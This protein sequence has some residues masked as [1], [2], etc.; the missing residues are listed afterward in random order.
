MRRTRP[1]VDRL[2]AEQRDAVEHP[3]GPLL[4]VAGPGTG[5]THVLVARICWLL[6][7]LPDISGENILA[8]TF[9]ERAAHEMKQRVEDLLGDRARGVWAGTFHS[10]C[11]QEILRPLCPGLEVLEDVDHWILL[12]R[13]LDQLG[14]EQFRRLAEPGRFLTDFCTFFSRCQDEL[15][16]PDEFE[17]YVARLAQQGADA[18]TLARWQEV[19]RAYRV[20]EQLLAQSLRVTFGGLL[21]EAIRVLDRHPEHL[22]RLRQRF[23]HILVDEFQDTNVAQIELLFRLAGE[24]RN[25][26]VVGDDDQAIYRF[27]GASF[28]SFRLFEQRCV[29]NSGPGPGTVLL[30]EN[31]RSTP[32]I[33]RVAAAVIACNADRYVPDKRL[34]TGRRGGPR[35]RLVELENAEQ[36]ACWVADEL[37]RLHAEGRPWAAC[38]VLYRQHRHRERLVLELARRKIPFVIRGLSIFTHTVV[39]DLLALLRLVAAPEDEIAC[40]RLLAAPHWR[41][42]PEDLVTLIHRARRENRSLAEQLA[43]VSEAGPG[44]ASVAEFLDWL[45]PLRA[46]AAEQSAAAF[47]D[48][49]LEQLRLPLVE[50]SPERP[51]LERFREFVRQWEAK[52]ATDDRSLRA[53]LQYLDFFLEADETVR[54]DL[55]PAKDA[56]ELMTVHAAKGLEF[57]CV[58]V[59]RLSQGDFPTRPRQPEFE[60]PAELL[61]EGQPEGDFHIQ[62]ERRLFYVALTRA[63]DLLTLTAVVNRRQKPSVFLDDILRAGR[64]VADVVERLQPAVPR[65]PLPVSVGTLDTPEA[66]PLLWHS[67]AEDTRAYS[68]IALWARS[69]VPP[70]PSPL[71]LTISQ[72]EDYQFCPTRFL[73]GALWRMRGRPHPAATFGDTIHRT[74]YKFVAEVARGTPM[75]LEE[76]LALYEREWPPAG[77][78]DSY[79]EREYRRAGEEQ[80][81][82]FHRRYLELR[83]TVHAQEKRFELPLEDTVV[84]RGRIDQLNRLPHGGFEVVDYKTGSARGSA[85]IRRSLQLNLYALAVQELLELRVDRFV[86]WNLAQDERV[87]IEPEPQELDRARQKVRE[88]AANIRAGRFEPRPGYLCRSCPFQPVCPAH[89]QLIPLAGVARAEPAGS[90]QGR[91]N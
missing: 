49:A 37:E 48:A 84:V 23:R 78:H 87:E 44:P 30:R 27:R 38:A 28:G 79:Q 54:L 8:L 81:R 66:A 29:S 36:E 47:V 80:L 40:A 6:G 26:F 75:P 53:F 88:I 13:N 5:K 31:Y 57:D 74:I 83:P 45:E 51:Y 16:S 19:A 71:E 59:L 33:L 82:A 50:D 91:H 10:F 24:D 7:T 69:F 14:L 73:F 4:V 9:T 64:E 65:E 32:P 62:E 20:S 58:F 89:E 90:G 1:I 12:R 70:L 18:R 46:L 35:V 22:E 17:A 72:L 55:Q 77:F 43:A 85:E 63:R 61:R 41:L 68:R 2:N 42:R 60:F 21:L 52:N 76:L 3:G 67:A 15:V 11:L 25:L 56:V 39:R 34:R 86:L